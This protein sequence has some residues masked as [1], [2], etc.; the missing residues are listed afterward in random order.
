MKSY[1]C[2]HFTYSLVAS[3]CTLPSGIPHPSIYV[4]LPLTTKLG[5]FLL[6][7]HYSSHKTQNICQTFFCLYAFNFYNKTCLSVW[8]HYLNLNLLFKLCVS[9]LPLVWIKPSSALPSQVTSSAKLILGRI[10]ALLNRL[11][12]NKVF[13]IM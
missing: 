3:S 12:A 11:V 6:S 9:L 8:I 2:M 10:K 5:Q 1:K 4:T 13:F 7:F